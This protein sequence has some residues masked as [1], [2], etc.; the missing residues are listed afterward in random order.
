MHL[1]CLQLG[2]Y[3]ASWGM[4]RG[5]SDLL[6]N[7]DITHYKK[8][9]ERISKADLKLWQIDVDKYC[10]FANIDKIVDMRNQI[11][12]SLIIASDILISKI[13]LA[14]F[15]NIPAFDKYFCLGVF[16]SESRK[17]L[18]K[19]LMLIH[20]LYAQNKTTL[21]NFKVN[22]ISYDNENTY[23]YSLAK[24]IDMYGFEKGIEEDERRKNEKKRPK[25]R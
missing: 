18:P 17:I 6:K 19:N 16:N 13:M 21:R 5:S 10:D 20:D 8:L 23:P 25:S 3:L 7:R 15:G 2:F 11:R 4:Y 9:I 24:K 12:E 22:T 1:S 14:V